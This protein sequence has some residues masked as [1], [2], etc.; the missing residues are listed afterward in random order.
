ML[1]NPHENKPKLS[2][3]LNPEEF[4]G[5]LDLILADR[6]DSA[7][8]RRSEPWWVPSVPC[9]E[10]ITLPSSY[11]TQSEGRLP[12]ASGCYMPPG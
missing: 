9:F 12:H 11:D 5:A 2:A 7:A 8:E 6:R 1:E 4:R 10:V 3:T